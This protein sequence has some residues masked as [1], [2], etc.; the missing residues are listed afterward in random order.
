MDIPLW[1]QEKQQKVSI[2]KG[3]KEAALGYLNNTKKIDGILGPD[4]KE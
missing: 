3:G 1:S 2:K 4:Q